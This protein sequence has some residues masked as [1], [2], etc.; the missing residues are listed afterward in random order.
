M[1]CK[2]SLEVKQAEMETQWMPDPCEQSSIAIYHRI[3][4]VILTLGFPGRF[5]G[6]EKA[7]TS[8]KGPETGP[9]TVGR[10]GAR[11]RK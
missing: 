5:L 11:R 9:K 3:R 4:R 2:S 10:F 8:F 1:I 7:R 6:V